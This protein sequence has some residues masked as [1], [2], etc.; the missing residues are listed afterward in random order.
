MARNRGPGKLDAANPANFDD[1]DAALAEETV[2]IDGAILLMDDLGQRLITH[3]D[4][5]VRIEAIGREIIA[6]KTRLAE[7][8]VRNTPADPN[9]PPVDT[10]SGGS[11]GASPTGR[12]PRG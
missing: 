2:V 11:G 1:L 8:I 4:D 7:S 3:K 12:G 6:R 5:P 9:P 10:L